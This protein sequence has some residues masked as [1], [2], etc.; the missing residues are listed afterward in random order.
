MVLISMLGA[1]IRAEEI[2]VLTTDQCLGI[3]PLPPPRVLARWMGGRAED[4][5]LLESSIFSVALGQ[6]PNGQVLVAQA[7]P[8]LHAVVYR[9]QADRTLVPMF[10]LPDGFL[11]M[12]I[13]S[14]RN[15]KVL[16]LGGLNGVGSVL[17]SWTPGAGAVVQ[18]LIGGVDRR[19]D[20]DSA[21]CTLIAPRSGTPGTGIYRMNVCAANPH[22]EFWLSLAPPTGEVFFAPGNRLLVAT[23]NHVLLLNASSGAT[24]RTYDVPGDSYVLALSSSGRSFWA[25]PASCPANFDNVVREYDIASGRLLTQRPYISGTGFVD[26]LP[27]SITVANGWRAALRDDFPPED[28][29]TLGAWHLLLLAVVLGVVSIRN[30]SMSIP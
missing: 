18:N 14:H 9:L 16:L 7:R 8:G 28:I 2:A 21:G 27:F 19:I 13:V 3:Q 20:L 1:T 23:Q 22:W 6:G 17:V 29:P 24:V 11:P 12:A 15:G 5:T 10:E 25:A 30:L 26:D 4:S